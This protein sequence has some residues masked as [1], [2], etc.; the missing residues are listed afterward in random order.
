VKSLILTDQPATRS[1]VRARIVSPKGELAVLSDGVTA[2]RH[3]SYLELRKG[4]VRG[5]HFH[6]VRNEQFYVFTGDVMMHLEEVASGDKTVVPLKPGDL[7]L[8]GPG[9]VHAFLPTSA[10]HALEFAPE[11]F[12]PA[13][14]YP[15]SVV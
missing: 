3:L 13:D 7:A 4:V 6:K 2:I 14:V 15:R 9:I 1:E 10:G 11:S 5:N 12:D 8:I